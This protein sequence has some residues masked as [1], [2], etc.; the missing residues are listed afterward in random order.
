MRVEYLVGLHLLKGWQQNV[1]LFPRLWTRRLDDH[2]F[3]FGFFRF[4]RFVVGTRQILSVRMRDWINLA[5]HINDAGV[6]PAPARQRLFDHNCGITHVTDAGHR[7][8]LRQTMGHLNQRTFAVAE[9][10]HVGFGIHQHRTTDGIR[11]VVVVRGTAQA[12]LNATKDHRHV[13]PRLFTALGIGQGGAIRALARYVIR[14]IGVVMAQLAIGG[15]AVDHR[16]HV[17]SGDAEEQIRF[18]EAHKVL[19][20]VPVR[21]GNDADA[22]ALSLQHTSADRHTEARVINIRIAGNQNDV[23]AVPAKLIHLFT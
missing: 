4:D 17:A 3:R 20:A 13:F 5:W 2:G 21:L 1:D 23:A 16:V 19:F 10:Q 11:P 12:R 18:A 6:D 15:V 8:A 22:E 14:R 9:D 7:L